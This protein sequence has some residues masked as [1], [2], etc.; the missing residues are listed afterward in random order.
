MGN[1]NAKKKKNPTELLEVNIICLIYVNKKNN[2]IIRFYK[3]FLRK[4]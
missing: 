2:I 1:K 3:H 4:K